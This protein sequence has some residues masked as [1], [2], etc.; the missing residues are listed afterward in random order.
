[1]ISGVVVLS[2][3]LDVFVS[4]SAL[5]TSERGSH[6]RSGTLGVVTFQIRYGGRKVG[7]RPTVGPFSLT[8]A[9]SL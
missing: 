5:A 8:T 1:M 3:N 7:H 2:S 9:S 4:F 6:L